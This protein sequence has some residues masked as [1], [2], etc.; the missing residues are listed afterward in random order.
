MPTAELTDLSLHYEEWGDGQPLLLIAGIPAIASDW[1]QLA[2]RL[3]DA[4]HRAIA[5]DNRGSGAST[6]TPGPYSTAQM[7]GDALALL[8]HLDVERTDVFGISMGGMI[9]QELALRAPDRIGH[10]VLGCTHA[11][12]AHAAPMPREAGRAFALDTDEWALRI[13][14]LAPFAFAENVDSALLDAFIVKKSADVQDPDGYAAQIQAVLAHDTAE[15]LRGIR[16][17]T[18]VLTGDDDRVIPGESSALLAERI[19]GASL[20][21][22]PGTGHLFFI[23]RLDDTLAILSEFLTSSRAEIQGSPA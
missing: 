5:Y 15:R 8:D 7:A 2:S 10:L 21:V 12:V 18:L 17:P 3:G 19:P 23:E 4:G 6:V 9:A 13:R 22:I 1:A 14:T 20:R 11:G 16:A